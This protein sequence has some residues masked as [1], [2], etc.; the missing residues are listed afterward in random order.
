MRRVHATFLL[1]SI[2][3]VASLT[4][5]APNGERPMP[6]PSKSAST[7]GPSSTP[8][9]EPIVYHPEGSAED[10]LAY[11]DLTNETLIESAGTPNGRQFIDALIAAGFVKA[12]MEVTEDKTAIN[13]GADSVQ[14]S[15]RFQSECLIGQFGNVG[16][17]ST[18]LPLLST[19][20]CLVGRTRPIDW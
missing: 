6:T 7:A 10:N 16:Y 8:T 17:G 11:F 13:L 19:G 14:F 12:D 2:V 9:A 4:A 15:V 3:A 1:A 5:C 20:K 18:I